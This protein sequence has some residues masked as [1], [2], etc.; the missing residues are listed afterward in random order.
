MAWHLGYRSSDSRGNIP[1]GLPVGSLQTVRAPA[2]LHCTHAMHPQ[3]L[4][5]GSNSLIVRVRPA[6]ASAVN[7]PHL[8]TTLLYRLTHFFAFITQKMA[9]LSFQSTSVFG[10]GTKLVK[11][12]VMILFR[13]NGLV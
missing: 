1:A 13:E 9:F 4:A 8:R 12:N 10:L 5:H 11:C 7:T 2:A 6:R 3:K